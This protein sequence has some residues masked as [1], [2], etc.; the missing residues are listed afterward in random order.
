MGIIELQVDCKPNP[1]LT[2]PLC[3]AILGFVA[4]KS[5]KPQ[6]RN[7]KPKSQLEILEFWAAEFA[8]LRHIAGGLLGGRTIRSLDE[9][10]PS[11]YRP[12]P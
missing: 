9:A 10:D 6:I 4:S 7:P 12:S 5:P 3:N 1:G 8:P 11:G 2:R